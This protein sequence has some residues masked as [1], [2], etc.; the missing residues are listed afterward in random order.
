[1]PA[2]SLNYACIFR[3]IFSVK[4]MFSLK[5]YPQSRQYKNKECNTDFLFLFFSLLITRYF[6]SCRAFQTKIISWFGRSLVKWLLIFKGRI[7]GI[8]VWL[9]H[10]I[11]RIIVG[12]LWWK[13]S[14]KYRIWKKTK[15]KNTKQKQQQ[16]TKKP[17]QGLL[18]FSPSFLFALFLCSF[19][20]SS[21]WC[22]FEAFFALK[23]PA[24]WPVRLSLK[25]LQ[26]SLASFL[27]KISSPH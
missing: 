1:M 12:P 7:L 2:S 5:H 27:K 21:A 18:R 23:K 10:E 17:R 16:K 8:P 25:W 19:S 26:F 14:P 24:F 3:W 6:L 11:V 20:F 9:S 15:T 4:Q 22:D 13:P